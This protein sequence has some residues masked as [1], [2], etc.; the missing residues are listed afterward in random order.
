M[1][2]RYEAQYDVHNFL[3]KNLPEVKKE[4]TS[5]PKKSPKSKSVKK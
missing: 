4:K 5:T 2:N 3:V 1:V